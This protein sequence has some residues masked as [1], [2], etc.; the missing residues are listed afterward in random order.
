MFKSWK[1]IKGIEERE[2]KVIKTWTVSW[3]SRYGNYNGDRNKE[4]EVFTNEAEAIQFCDD[5]KNAHYDLLKNKV[6]IEITLKSN[7]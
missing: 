2:V 3:Y 6:D 1:K 5:L 7:N 4:F